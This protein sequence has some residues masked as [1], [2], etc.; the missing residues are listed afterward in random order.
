MAAKIYFCFLWESRSDLDIKIKH[1]SVEWFN[2]KNHDIK[3]I[4]SINFGRLDSKRE[5]ICI[6]FFCG[7]LFD[8]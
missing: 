5:L 6:T 3:I 4:T 1:L 8:K 2:P 7:N